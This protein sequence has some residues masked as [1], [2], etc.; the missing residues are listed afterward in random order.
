M[1]DEFT[2]LRLERSCQHLHTLG[3][4]ATAELLIEVAARIGGMPAILGALTEF[5]RSITPAMVRVAGGDRFPRR[6]LRAVPR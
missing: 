2:M 1:P 5:E 3:P 6:Q 4:R